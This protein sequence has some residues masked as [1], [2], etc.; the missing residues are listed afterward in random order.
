MNIEKWQEEKYG[1]KLPVFI[2]IEKYRKELEIFQKAVN[3]LLKPSRKKRFPYQGV[4][5][6]GSGARG[7]MHEFSDWDLY[8]LV[9]GEDK[10]NRWDKT[11]FG[12]ALKA[13]LKEKR[14]VDIFGAID[15]TDE[16]L[17]QTVKN[18]DHNLIGTPFIVVS[19]LDKV[20]KVFEI[21]P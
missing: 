14:S 19:P 2:S 6:Y 16:E 15:F 21:I 17:A 11:K 3:N 13:K 20:R 7:D 8:L 10:S 18:G 5:V 9:E 12:D 4:I 1:E